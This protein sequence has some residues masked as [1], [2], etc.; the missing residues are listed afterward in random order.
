MNVAFIFLGIVMAGG[1]MLLYHEFKE[2]K[3]GEQNAAFTGFLLMGIAGVGTML[4][5]IFPENTNGTM[6]KTG[7]G[8]AIGL[9]NLGMFFLGAVLRGLPEGLRRYMLVFSTFSLTALVLF[10]SHQDFGIGPGTMERGAAYPQTIWLIIF[11]LYVLRF[12]PGANPATTVSSTVPS[13]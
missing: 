12:R 10:A 6:H 1:S 11:G 4:V 8:L 2:R 5:G 9:G 7:A 3:G 13:G